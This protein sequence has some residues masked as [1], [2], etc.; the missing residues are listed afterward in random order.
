VQVRFVFFLMQVGICFYWVFL[1]SSKFM[2][3]N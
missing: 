2:G 1:L 3:G